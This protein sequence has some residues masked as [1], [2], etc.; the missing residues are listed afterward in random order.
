[1]LTI[2]QTDTKFD[3]K[4]DDFKWILLDTFGQKYPSASS[5]KCPQEEVSKPKTA[6]L[7]NVK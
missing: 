2:H 3:T 1:M 6:F 5:I 4:A 7:K